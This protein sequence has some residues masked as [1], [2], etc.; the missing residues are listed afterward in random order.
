MVERR[1]CKHGFAL[2]L[3]SMVIM[4]AV[5]EIYRFSRNFLYE[6][7]ESADA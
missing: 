1:N 5:D 4:K 6:L 2:L 7:S 3:R